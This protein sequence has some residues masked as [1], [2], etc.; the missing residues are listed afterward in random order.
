PRPERRAPVRQSL[1]LCETD[2]VIVQVARLAYLKDHVTALRTMGRLVR[3]VP[4]AKL[5]L[6]GDG[7]KREVIETEIQAQHVEAAVRL[8]GTREDVPELLWAA[9]VCLLSSLSEG[10]PVTLIEAMA[11]QLPVV[12]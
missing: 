8:L 4:T 11:A 1:G 3:Q 7:P 10:I 6:V 2:F 12:A 5:L 9:D